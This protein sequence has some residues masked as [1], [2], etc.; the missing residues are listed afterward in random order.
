MR[1]IFTLA[2]QLE[3]LESR[4][5]LTV[6]LSGGVLT[7]TGGAG[8]DVL[9]M[10]QVKSTV[11][12]SSNGHKAQ[13][14]D[15][16]QINS[17]SINMGS[18]NDRV[19]LEKLDGADPVLIKAFISGSKGD[20][21]LRGGNGNDT[22]SG[23]SGDDL[24]DG[25]LGADILS[26]DVGIDTTDYST[27]LKAITV[28]FDNVAN[29]G[30]ANEHDNVETEGVIGGAGNDDF[31]MDAQDTGHTVRGGPGTDIVDYEQLA[32]APAPGA[33]NPVSLDDVANDGVNGADNIRSDVENI[34]G[35]NFADLLIGSDADN[36]LLGNDGNDKIM[37]GKGNDTLSGGAGQDSMLGEGGDDFMINFNFSTGAN[38][39]NDALSGGTG[40]NFDEPDPLDGPVT[41]IQND[42]DSV[43]RSGKSHAPVAL[44][45]IRPLGV[46]APLVING[47]TGND[48]IIINQNA[49]TVSYTVNGVKTEVASSTVNQ[50]VVNCD[51]GDDLVLTARPT[52]VQMLSPSRQTS[53]ATTE[54]T[55]SA[56][57]PTATRSMAGQATIRSS[58]TTATIR[59]S[60]AWAAISSSAPA[61]M[62]IWSATPTV[63]TPLALVPTTSTA[64]AG[65]I[66]SIITAATIRCASPW[67]TT[68]P[69]T[70]GTTAPR[71]TTCI[72]TS[73]T[74]SA[75]TATTASSE[76]TRPTSSPAA[77]GTIP[78]AA[79]AGSTNSSATPAQIL[80]RAIRTL[81]CSSCPTVRP[82]FSTLPWMAPAIPLPTS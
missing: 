14:F 65:T 43:D 54:T 71:V 8:D 53:S 7:I 6:T 3:H 28:S 67:T 39:D 19:G 75:A 34:Y 20:D 73:K 72:P 59:S 78:C 13:T 69:T 4:T 2:Q 1:P 60:A 36:V 15:A 74:A 70:A 9:A 18:G 35:S 5:L 80:S 64:T 62:I 24:L 11:F 55:Q 25:G 58:A 42:Y 47:T 51:L 81:T 27:R 48:T 49:T 12:V 82:T 57:D 29:D 77:A 31:V 30:E 68:S 23:G 32:V 61:A 17:I 63:P 40:V 76:T 46:P 38:P 33:F 41:G 44:G 52:T 26:G 66:S 16:S 21:T 10:S 37:G 50:I 56:V 45:G 79:K 22:I